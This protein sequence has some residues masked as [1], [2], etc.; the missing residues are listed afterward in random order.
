MKKIL[1][2]LP[3]NPL[4]GTCLLLFLFL[5]LCVLFQK[6]NPLFNRRMRGEQ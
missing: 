6:L 4:K 1:A 2:A 3:L 5:T